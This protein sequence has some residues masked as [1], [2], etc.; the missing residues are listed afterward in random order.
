MTE[1][2]KA[3]IRQLARNILTT[4]KLMQDRVFRVRSRQLEKIG[5]NRDFSD[6]T[7]NQLHAILMIHIRGKVSV[8]ELSSLLSVSPPSASV[9][10]D[11]L[12]EKGI[13]LREPCRQDRRKVEIRIS[14]KLIDTIQAV[15]DAILDSF[16]DLVSEI[17]IETAEKWCQVLEHVKPILQ[18][19]ADTY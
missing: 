4:G 10:V 7:A 12:V 17:G 14:A 6:L 19:E 13:L 9:M 15:E 2:N 5:R 8:N 3:D 16:V 1:P 11:R 18:R